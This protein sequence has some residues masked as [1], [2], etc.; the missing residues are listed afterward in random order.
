MSR[1]KGQN[2]KVRVKKRVNG[3]KVF[4]F[5]YWVD[6]PGVEERKR[7]TEV[8][9][10]VSQM[11]KSEANRKKLEFLSKLELNSSSYQLPCS[12][13][14]ADAVKHYREKFGPM[15]HRESTRSVWEGRIK[16]HLEPDWKD[17][18]LD[19]ITF[20][21]VSEW[22]AKKREAGLSWVLIKDVLRTMQRVISAFT[23]DHK[24][25]FSQ[26]G[27][28]PEREKLRMRVQD[29][30]K[31]SYSWEDAERIAEHVRKMDGL[32]ES[33]REQ[34]ATLILLAAASGLRC[35]E[36]LA[37]RVHDLDF[38]ASSITVDEAS[39]QRT[40]G[41][42]G[43][44]K[45]HSAY[46]TVL[47]LDAEG[48]KAM[49]CLRQFVRDAK[50]ADT[51]VF[52]SQRGGPLL[53]TTIL[54]QCLHPSVKALGLPRSGFHAFRRGCNRRWEL[55]GLNPAVHRQMMGH[56]SA[57]MTRLYTGE[58]PLVDMA[59]ACFKAFGKELEILETEAAA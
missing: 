54:N 12:L 37:L 49:Q 53:E 1:R 36:L 18:P 51:L 23:K 26:R 6:L 14:F 28:L 58:I 17:V 29:R 15:M 33:R 56:S 2:P 21:A 44:C 32:G 16:N 8:I 11:T 48:K 24:V 43:E 27:L 47:V 19:M 41:R 13:T 10:P 39:D 45:N 20:D 55:A 5:Q 4:Y 38:A 3:E 59:A 25:P 34:Y 42:V 9:G 31:V 57:S 30:K 40:A 52:R 46:R 7:M 50:D 22:A 35:S